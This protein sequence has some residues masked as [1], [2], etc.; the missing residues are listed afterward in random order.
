MNMLRFTTGETQAILHRLEIGE[1]IAEVFADTDGI[2]HLAPLVE[3]RAREMAFQLSKTHNIE[4]K[5]D[6]ELDMEILV[7][8]LDGSTWYEVHE[9]YGEASNQ[10]LTA[11]TNSLRS[12]A[13]KVEAFYN[14]PR[15]DINVVTW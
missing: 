7:D 3:A 9:G 5:G 15:G 6:C 4:S 1:C 14:I 11:I 8:C 12:A 10:K 13:A 2:E